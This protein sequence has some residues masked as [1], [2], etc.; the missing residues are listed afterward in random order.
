[1]IN[2]LPGFFGPGEFLWFLLRCVP[3]GPGAEGDA[4]RAAAGFF[5]FFFSNRG[6]RS[7][8]IYLFTPFA[9]W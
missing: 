2:Y 6:T 1:M 7:V 5:F 3:Q 8:F 9:A 4:V